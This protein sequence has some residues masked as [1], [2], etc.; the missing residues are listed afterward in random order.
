V[1]P[2]FLSPSRCAEGTT[3]SPLRRA[4]DGADLAKVRDLSLEGIVEVRGAVDT[5][6]AGVGEELLRL[7]PRRGF[8]FTNADPVEAVE[9][10]RASGVLAYDMTGAYAGIAIA[11]ERVLRRLTDL[12]PARIPTA[13]PFAHVSALFRR[14]ADG[15]IHVYVH[16]ELGHY[17]AE[18]TLDA[19]AGLAG[20]TGPAPTVQGQEPAQ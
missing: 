5:V 3:T 10:L 7:T 15:W 12:D 9:R 17:A 16:Q 8:L 11:D 2:A 4:L 1:T 18:A 19:I 6:T 14:G 13:A 20:R